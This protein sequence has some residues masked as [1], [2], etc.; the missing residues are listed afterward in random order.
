MC[1]GFFRPSVF[2][3]GSFRAIAKDKMLSV[4]WVCFLSV[5]I[6]ELRVLGAIRFSLG[7][8]F[9]GMDSG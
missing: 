6:L 5:L 8:V 7:P 1:S 9:R 4:F 3:L 2:F